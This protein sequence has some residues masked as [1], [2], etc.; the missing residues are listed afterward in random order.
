KKLGV[1]VFAGV[2]GVINFAFASAPDTL[3][4]RTYGG[5]DNDWGNSVL[6]T[7]DGGIVVSGWTASFGVGSQN[8]YLIKT[9]SSGDTLW[10]R[11]YGGHLLNN[12]YCVSETQ[13]S[14]FVIVGETFSFGA[15]APSYSN[16]YLV[17]TNSLGDTLWTRTYGG[18]KGECGWSVSKTYDGGF[19][20]TGETTSFGAGS[21]NYSNVY[22]VKTNSSGDALWTKT[23]GGAT[24]NSGWSV[25]EPQDSGFII[26]GT[27]NS[28][29]IGSPNYS[30]VYL[31]RTN[32]SG[33]TL[34]TRAFGGTDNDGCYSVSETQDNG[35]IMVG[36]TSS[37]G[38]G[39]HDVYLIKTNSSG[40]TLCTRTYGGAK[41]DW[42]ESVSET[43]DSGFIIAAKK[44]SFGAGHFDVYLIRTNS[45]G[46]TLWTKTIGGAESEWG[47]S[48][49]ETRDRGFI[50]AG[51]T[52]GDDYEDVYLIR[53]KPETGIEERFFANT[54]NNRL[55][56]FSNPLT[57]LSEIK[58][59]L[60]KDTYVKIDIYN[61]VGI[62]LATI[63]E[64]NQSS[65]KHTCHLSE[66]KLFTSG[67]YFIQF[68]AGDYKETKKL[69]LMK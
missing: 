6:E 4:T 18:T 66:N 2:I 68:S 51:A 55:E 17:R 50:V 15:G 9:N 34:W 7:Q 10:T 11:T 27:T 43:Q 47:C 37:F 65:G 13:D 49:S 54:Q 46:D 24:G 60:Q 61:I 53:L 22:L 42:G 58:Y 56:M 29:G 3:W 14:G 16:A 52:Y 23:F 39:G 64:G 33:D 44:V 41:D 63:V 36:T 21:P 35:F 28:F 57:T 12:G 20:I 32:S 5:T 45:S 26:V 19:I 48:V 67:I 31:V 59:E 25:S 8:F 38:A 40:D 69:I 1:W 62:K 30:N